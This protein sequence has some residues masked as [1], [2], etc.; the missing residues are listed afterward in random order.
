MFRYSCM[1][2]GILVA[3]LFLASLVTCRLSGFPFSGES[4]PDWGKHGTGVNVSPGTELELDGVGQMVDAVRLTAPLAVFSSSGFDVDT[5]EVYAPARV[6]FGPV[7]QIVLTCGNQ[8]AHLGVGEGFFGCN[9]AVGMTS[10]HLDK[11]QFLAV[12]GHDIHFSV[13]TTIVGGHN[14]IPVVFQESA[15]LLLSPG[16][17]SSTRSGHFSIDPKYERPL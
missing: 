17:Q 9:E 6:S 12:L 8:P 4:E 7:L 3:L 14:A 15:C 16:S 13:G 11:H 2:I 1:I 10:A 5:N